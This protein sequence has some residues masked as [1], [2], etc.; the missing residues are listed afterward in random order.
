M[1][2]TYFHR[3]LK[4]RR[5]LNRLYEITNKD[6]VKVNLPEDIEQAFISYYKELLGSDI[7]SRDHVKSSLVKTG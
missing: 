6:G 3:S 2:T 1:N 4:Q 5:I 7:Q